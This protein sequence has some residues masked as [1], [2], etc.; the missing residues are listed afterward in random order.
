MKQNG[1]QFPDFS[2]RDFVRLSF[3]L[4][5]AMAAF[6]FLQACARG[7]GQPLASVPSATPAATAAELAPIAGETATAEPAQPT[8][9]QPE[10]ATETPQET[11]ASE[12]SRIALVQTTD[13][14][15]G[16][17][18]A[19]ALL[20]IN[21]VQGQEVLLKPNFN[22]AD[23]SP[24]S[25]HPDV[26]RTL[27]TLL[28]EMGATRI[29]VGDRSGMGDTNAVMR[30]LGVFEMAAELGFDTL[31]FDE[32]RLNEWREF[33]LPG[34]HWGQG[35]LF[36]APCLD[37]GALVQTCCLKT[38]RFGGVFTLSL[39]NS[40]GMVA[41]RHPTSGYNYMT[42]LHNSS[43]QR[44]MIAEINA[45]YTPALVVLDGVEAF[46]SGGPDQGKKAAPGVILAGVDRVA[47]DALGVAILR[48]HGASF[49]GTIYEQPQIA[50]AIELG[51]GAGDPGQIEILTEDANAAAYA[52][53]LKSSLSET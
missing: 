38:H 45:A 32:L 37:C 28:G 34:A 18:R 51:L 44:H 25:T 6:S 12:A 35:F 4:G 26:L 15:D 13:R 2:R 5:S 7:S 36:A 29:T 41:K 21:P 53:Q 30:A 43:W 40:V 33:K 50:R 49:N 22:S 24:G 3:L 42:E 17:R 52:E 9:Q 16:V 48:Q 1:E 10:A 11:P 20:G 27:V 47:I 8:V 23:P 31:N 19:L 14:A 39:K 46:V